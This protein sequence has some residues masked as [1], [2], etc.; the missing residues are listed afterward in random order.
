MGCR[1]WPSDF[2]LCFKYSI[3]IAL[4]S[5]VVHDVDDDDDDDEDEEKDGGDRVE[6]LDDD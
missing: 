2:S 5:A 1:L 4:G 6:E 3:R